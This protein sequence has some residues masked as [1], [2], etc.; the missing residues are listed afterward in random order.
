MT[1]KKYFKALDGIRAVSILMICWFHLWEQSWHNFFH[2]ETHLLKF[3]GITEISPEIM[4]RMGFIF[5][6]CML[7]LSAVL[8]FMPYARAIVCKEP[9]PDTKTFYK[10]RFVRIFPSYLFCVLVMFIT[11]LV[12]GSYDSLGFM[13]K[14]LFTRLTF[15][16]VFFKDTA[17]HSLLNG[18]LWTVMVEVW[19][20]ILIPFLAKLIKKAPLIVLGAMFVLGTVSG[21]AFI[22]RGSDLWWLSNHPLPFL[23]TYAIGFFVALAYCVTLGKNYGKTKQSVVC[24]CCSLISLVG[25][26]FMFEAF[27][28]AQSRPMSQ[29][30]YRPV[31]AVL[32]GLIIYAMMIAPKVVDNLIGNRFIKW[33]CG[34]SYNLYIWHQV[35]AL[36]LKDARIPY[37][38]GTE[39]PNTVYNYAWMRKYMIICWA[40]SI[41]VAVFTTKYVEGGARELLTRGSLGGNAE[42]VNVKNA[43]VHKTSG[44]RTLL[45]TMVSDEKSEDINESCDLSESISL[46][47]NALIESNNYHDL[48]DK[49]CESDDFE[50]CKPSGEDC[51]T[52]DLPE[53]E[54]GGNYIYNRLKK[55]AGRFTDYEGYALVAVLCVI[56]YFII[57]AMFTGQRIGVGNTYN[58]YSLQADCWRQGRLDLGNDYSYL[59]VAQYEGKYY[60]SF[61]LFPSYVVFPFTFIFHANT[62][63]HMLCLIACVALVLYLY[64]IGLHFKLKPQDACLGATF[65]MLGTNVVFNSYNPGVWFWAQTLCLLMSTM[66]IY[67]ALKGKGGVSLFCWAA[68]VGCRPMQ[69]LYVP[70]LLIILYYVEYTKNPG[71][72]PWKIIKSRLIWAIPPCVLA[73][74]YMIL[75][76]LRFD[77]PLEFGHNYLPE[78]VEA[79]NGQFSLHY[80]AD[81][82]KALLHMPVFNEEHKM[83]IDRFGNLNFMIASPYVIFAIVMLIVLLV[84]KQKKL[85]CLSTV[86]AVLSVAYL[87][88]TLMHKTMGG[89]SFGNRYTNDI[90]PWLY[91]IGVFG[92]SKCSKASK[93]QIPL[94]MFGMCL[95]VVGS[96]YVYNNWGVMY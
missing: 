95:N 63:D 94:F 91:I 87:A 66:S 62:P 75:N 37:W 48:S 2:Y 13:V 71:K 46:N 81:N 7:L 69:A 32:F 89:W 64:K 8:N 23:S 57:M 47:E 6:D 3:I 90:L 83:E 39:Y 74:S 79:E 27:W 36:W 20:Y 45:K 21:F 28:N 10:K 41:I 5:V 33:F 35:I 43:V 17:R 68:S 88:V 18:V 93:Y 96:I 76:Y 85:Y 42:G 1:D 19:F 44:L 86:I 15:S 60:I 53:G 92:V 12:Q 61:P 30:R 55:A 49:D 73:G 24:L 70:V 52:V 82:F 38:S 22:N 29:L 31:L 40:V 72:K 9:W 84:K 67:Y 80:M 54:N 50:D 11:S 26:F 77:N 58:S 65:M 14:D 25:L 16:G 51:G 59:E 34:I 56:A 4:V 78:F